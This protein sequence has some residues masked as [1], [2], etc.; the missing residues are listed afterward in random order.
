MLEGFAKYRCAVVI[1]NWNGSEHL[2][3]FL[4]SVV[5]HTPSWVDIVVADNG[6]SDCSCFVVK[7]EFSPRVELLMM[8]ENRGFAGGY[9]HALS[10]LPHDYFILLNSDVEVE[11]QWVEPLIE[12]MESDPTVGITGSKLRS[13]T[14]PEMFEYA[15]AAGGFIDYL[16]YPYCRGRVMSHIERDNGQYDD[17]RDLFWVSGA[18]LSIR[19]S[20]FKELGGFDTDFFAHMEEIDLCWRAQLLGYRVRVVP[21]S[22]VYHLGGGTLTTESPHKTYLN[23]RNNLAMLYKCAPPIQ[24]CVVAVVRPVLDLA[25]A[26]SYLLQGRVESFWAVFQAWATFLKWHTELTRKRNAIRDS[27]RQESKYIY[28]GSIILHTR[29]R[30][31]KL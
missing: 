7:S 14:H 31:P 11:A 30:L 18:A 2:R 13:Y 20:L 27:V 19:A 5:E 16:G 6:S 4:P 23:H 29:R 22:V 8:E 28:K 17:A 10:Q 3:K 15:G 1:L 24:R 21:Q 9:N 26:L 25:A 12:Q